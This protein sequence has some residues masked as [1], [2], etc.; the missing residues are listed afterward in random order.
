MNAEPPVDPVPA[1]A[2]TRRGAGGD[3][4]SS[5][6]LDEGL[7]EAFQDVLEEPVPPV[8]SLLAAE[9]E[10]RLHAQSGDACGE[11]RDVD[12]KQSPA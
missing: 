8:L 7:R 6:D 2:P 10:R 3:T 9:L 11:R 12:P 1:T 4:R 5:A